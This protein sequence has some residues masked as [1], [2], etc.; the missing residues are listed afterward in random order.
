MG[1]TL[2]IGAIQSLHLSEKFWRGLFLFGTRCLLCGLLAF[3]VGCG[4]NGSATES[5]AQEGDHG[6]L[7]GLHGGTIASLGDDSYHVEAV[8]EKGGVLR[9]YTLGA[10]ESRVID[11]EQQTLQGFV[12]IEGES[13]AFAFTLQPEPV[14]GDTPGRTSQFVGTLPEEVGGRALAV[15]VPNIAISGE[16][17]RLGFR[18]TSDTHTPEMPS[19]VKDEE[20]LTLYL[21][22]GG[23]YTVE[24]IAANGNITASEKFRGMRAAHDMNPDAGEKICPITM[25]KA[26]P[27]FTWIVGGEAYE[28]CCPP[29]VD[30]F[31]MLAKTSPD[32]IGPPEDY[33]RQ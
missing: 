24:D 14:D 31:V 8:F 32:E 23:K 3:A 17:F 16:R 29:C 27:D 15:T 12:K 26:N 2:L 25:T 13:E 7:P 18:S 20:E 9:L 22:P 5:P 10:D 33:V 21:T 6:H 28:F 1:A 30:E 4:E 11:V 19:K